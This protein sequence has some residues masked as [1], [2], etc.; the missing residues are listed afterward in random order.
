MAVSESL[1][2]QLRNKLDLAPKAL[3]AAL[4]QQGGDIDKALLHVIDTGQ[5]MYTQLQ[6][7]EIADALF[8][9]AHKGYLKAELAKHAA[10]AKKMAHDKEMRAMLRGLCDSIREQLRDPDEFRGLREQTLRTQEIRDRG[11][12]LRK[13]KVVAK[14]PPFPPLKLDLNQWTGVDTLK[15][16]AG[17]QERHGAYT[18]RSSSRPSKGTVR[19]EMDRLDDD[20]DDDANPAPPAP[21]QVAAYRHLK[22]NEKLITSRILAAVLKAFNAMKRR[23]FF[24][25]V[26]DDPDWYVPDLREPADLKRNIGLGTL[27][28]LDYAKA[29]HAY[30]G[31]E[32][33][34]TWDEEHGL[35]VLLHK[36][37]V[38][39]VGDSEVSFNHHAAKRDGGKR[40]T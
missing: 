13:A 36:S 16:W 38:V 40:I 12:K 1:V 37:R 29:G 34:C 8:V 33:G 2:R 21:E 22:E 20:R 30:L 26:A 18:S 4:E 31:L 28:M 6:A 23:G 25:D 7:R 39:K 5:V 32:F 3:R 11:R 27:H 24:D 17:F 15:S 9:R 19:I 14:I 10:L 35:G